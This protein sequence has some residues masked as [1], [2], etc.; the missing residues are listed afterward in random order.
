MGLSDKTSIAYFRNKKVFADVFNF[1]IYGGREVICEED[2]TLISG[3]P[4]ALCSASSSGRK[5]KKRS[6]VH[7]GAVQ[8]QRDVF[9]QTICMESK[10]IT[11]LLLGIES[12]TNISYDMPARTMLYDALEYDEQIREIKRRNFRSKKKPKGSAE[13]LRMY[14]KTDRINPVVT[15]VVYLGSGPWDGPRSLYDMF[16]FQ[17]GDQL[18]HV[19][20]YE[21]D[22]IEPYCMSEEEIEKFQSSM[23]EVMLYLKYA[24]RRERLVQLAEQERF[25]NIDPVAVSLINEVTGSFIEIPEGE[26][27]VDVA[28][29]MCKAWQEISDEA[30]ETGLAQGLEQGL[31]QGLAQGLAQGMEQGMAQGIAQEKRKIALN[32]MSCGM[33]VAD[34][35]RMTEATEESVKEWARSA[36]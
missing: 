11:Y 3:S 12:Q 8:K 9:M 10:S 36:R 23:R 20:N 14:Y 21:M 15:L 34:V 17:K 29:K 30:R 6:R 31:E 13:F 27:E 22:L 19:K 1:W 33:A 25:R 2:L 35:A 28:K 16:G 32:L 4:V 5:K 26:E 7:R 18:T 24:E